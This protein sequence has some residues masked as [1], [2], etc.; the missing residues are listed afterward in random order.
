MKE[1]SAPEKKES[2]YALH[3][4][5][6]LRGSQLSVL[7]ADEAN[8]LAEYGAVTQSISRDV[9]VP[10]TLAL[11]QLHY[12]INVAFGWT[13]S[14]LHKFELP[15][16]LLQKLT[17]GT[18][19]EIAPLFGYYLKFPN[20][21]F[22]DDFWD[23]DYDGSKNLR[24]W[25]R[26]KYLKRYR[27][28]GFSNFWIENQAE[29]LDFAH[30]VPVLNVRPF[31][32]GV[33]K[34]QPRKVKFEKAT[35]EELFDAIIFDNG[36]PDVLNE[37]LLLSEILSLKPTDIELAKAGALATD[38]SSVELYTKY[39]D[40]AVIEAKQKDFSPEKSD[41]YYAIGQ[42]RRLHK[43]SQPTE[44]MPIANNLLY[45]YDF[46]DGWE[47]EISLGEEF[48]KD[49]EL[50][51]NEIAAKVIESRKPICV[52]KDGLPVLDDC[53]HVSGYVEMLRAI[54][55][56]ER[57]EAMEMKTWARGQGWTGKDVSPEK[58]I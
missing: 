22:D 21:I 56:G 49:S 11:H 32:W 10:S 1:T 55:E 54:H 41:Y 37:S 8:I 28:Q 34:V 26:S 50:I 23:D 16:A 7:P 27:Y 18:M 31:S 30:K 35:L 5:L 3:L 17:K 19:L 52:A 48:G 45:S 46:G 24:T 58:L 57:D 36:M 14:H 42:M 9:I 38:S 39:R 29:I 2:P 13:N 15:P 25:M 53:G 6:E 33:Q 47:V 51:T 20:G 44:I 43:A 40:I 4:H 12:L